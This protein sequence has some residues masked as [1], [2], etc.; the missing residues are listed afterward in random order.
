[1]LP[2]YAVLPSLTAVG[3]PRKP[4]CS[5]R[6]CGHKRM[7]GKGDLTPLF[8]LLIPQEAAGALPSSELQPGLTAPQGHLPLLAL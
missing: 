3:A 2:P 7:A 5:Q 6:L 1:M 8:A 4:L